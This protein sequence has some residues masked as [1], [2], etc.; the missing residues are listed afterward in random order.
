[1]SWAYVQVTLQ[2]SLTSNACWNQLEMF[3]GAWISGD[4]TGV[5]T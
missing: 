5:L 1:M 3:Q 4:G 2:W